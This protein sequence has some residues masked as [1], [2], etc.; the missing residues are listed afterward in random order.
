MTDRAVP[1]RRVRARTLLGM[2]GAVAVLALGGVWLGQGVDR[3]NAV[4]DAPQT[5]RAKKEQ[6]EQRDRATASADFAPGAARELPGV[7]DCGYGEPLLEPKIITLSCANGGAVASDIE[8]DT[9]AADKAEGDGVVLVSS[10]ANGSA[11]TSFPARL[12]LSRPRKVDGMPAFTSVEVVY[13]GLT[14]AGKT[15]ETYSIT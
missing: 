1:R 9:Y 7:R 3:A 13:T 15:T 6:Q 4:S 8:W 14:P 12:T 11:R 2:S 5:A 10:G